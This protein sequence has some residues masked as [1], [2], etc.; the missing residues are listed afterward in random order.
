MQHGPACLERRQEIV[1]DELPLRT[2]ELAALAGNNARPSKFYI[3][4]RLPAALAAAGLEPLGFRTQSIDRQA[5]LDRHLALFLQLYLQALADRIER[6]APAA[7]REA[8]AALIDRNTPGFL[9][10][11]PHFTM[12]WT[13]VLA[14]GRRPLDDK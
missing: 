4:R 1:I 12:T 2:A 11:A 14:W 9:L 7:L 6:T 8:L 5:P 13:N 10:H 3:G